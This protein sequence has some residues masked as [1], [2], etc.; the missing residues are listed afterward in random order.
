MF[1]ESEGMT[2]VFATAKD[3]SPVQLPACV[4]VTL[5]VPAATPVRSSEVAPFDHKKE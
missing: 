2:V 1:C 4:T 3:A 5:Y